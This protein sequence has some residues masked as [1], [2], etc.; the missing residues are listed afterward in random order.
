MKK[1]IPLTE[2]LLENLHDIRPGE[3]VPFSQ[4]YV[5]YHWLLDEAPD[6]APAAATGPK[7]TKPEKRSTQ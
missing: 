4:G 2:E 7:E 1:F 5:C 3:C 6:G